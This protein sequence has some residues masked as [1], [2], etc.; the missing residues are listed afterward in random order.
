MSIHSRTR[1]GNAAAG[2]AVAAIIAVVAACSGAA[3]VAPPTTGTAATQE[4]VATPSPATSAAA[5]TSAPSVAA[6]AAGA[7]SGASGAALTAPPGTPVLVD[8]FTSAGIATTVDTTAHAVDPST[9][10]TTIPATQY[11]AVYVVFALKPDAVGKVSMVM[12]LGDT[13]VLEKPL[14]IDYGTVNSWGDFKVTFPGSGIPTG[15]YKAV[16]TFEPTGAQVI[17]YFAVN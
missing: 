16:M 2:L 14:E 11:Q 1:S 6:S 9:Y 3:S 7:S 12:S 4:T 13:D 5:A 8:P 10:R 15:I 17:Q